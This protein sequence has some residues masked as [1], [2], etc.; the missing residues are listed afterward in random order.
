MIKNKK[1]NIGFLAIQM[2]K[3]ATILI[4]VI[5]LLLISNI[6]LGCNYCNLSFCH[7]TTE[8][9]VCNC[10][11]CN[12]QALEKF[13]T[14]G[15]GLLSIEKIDGGLIGLAFGTVCA[16]GST[17]YVATEYN[18]SVSYDNGITYVNRTTKDG[19]TSGTIFGIYASGD[20]VY[21]ATAMGLSISTNRGI[22]F[23]NKLNGII[24][25]GVC[26]FDNTLY[27]ATQCGLFISHNNGISFLKKTD[28]FGTRYYHNLKMLDHTVMG[29][30]ASDDIVCAVGYGLSVSNNKGENFTI[31]AEYAN[32]RFC[33]ISGSGNII[34]VAVKKYYQIE[35]QIEGLSPMP[36]TIRRGLL[37]STNKG[38]TF[39]NKTTKDGLADDGVGMVYVSSDNIIYAATKKGLSV[40]ADGG[41]TFT[42][43]TTDDG[44]I[45]N[46]IHGVYA[47]GNTLY[48]TTDKGLSIHRV[49][50]HSGNVEK[51]N[52]CN[53][54]TKLKCARCKNINYCGKKC[55]KR[56]W[57]LH[58]KTCR[59]ISSTS[60]SSSSSSSASSSSSTT[61]VSAK[62]S[63]SAF[64]LSL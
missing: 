35:E 25:F 44:L 33:E 45:S 26:V 52:V 27:V 57:S 51:C 22:T 38:R 62:K 59:S 8:T 15:A 63:S 18:L 54:Y 46:V 31:I 13:G 20:N 50:F 41:S 16:S 30:Y 43:I 24:V 7:S 1:A 9:N 6:T 49:R 53:R 12:A 36:D 10:D 32:S 40:S 14:D 28:G 29:V 34:C 64:S 37:L 47:S 48:V 61:S 58:K 56:D 11:Y 42:N 39:V 19:L 4:I 55:Q 60:S 2:K 23:D 21:V 3:V 5:H 17:I